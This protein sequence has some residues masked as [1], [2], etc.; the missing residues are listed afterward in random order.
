MS[1]ASSG[2]DGEGFGDPDAD[3]V[4]TIFPIMKLKC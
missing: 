2:F 3:A 1:L 4:A